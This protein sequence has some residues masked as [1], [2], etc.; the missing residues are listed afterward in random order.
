MMLVVYLTGFFMTG[1]L[2]FSTALRWASSFNN[3]SIEEYSWPILLFLAY[4]FFLFDIG[5]LKTFSQFK[6]RR[7]YDIIAVFLLLFLARLSIVNETS[8]WLDEHIQALYSTTLLPVAAGAIQHQPPG[9]MVLTNLGLWIS[10]FSVWGLRFHSCLFSAL[11]GAILFGLAKYLS[12]SRVFGLLCMLF[13]SVHQIVYKYGYEARPI[14]LGLFM[15][16]LFL[17][18]LLLQIKYISEKRNRRSGLYLSG[19]T[20]IYL[21]SL[22]LQPAF[23]VGL[24]IVFFTVLACFKREYIG[25]AGLLTLGL[26]LF[27]PLQVFI[28]SLAPPRFT[29][30]E[31]LNFVRTFE[32]FKYS[33]FSMLSIYYN[34]IGYVCILLSL[35]YAAIL[36]FRRKPCD[37]VT[38]FLIFLTIFFPIALIPYFKAHIEWELLNHYLVSF[39]PL[40]FLLFAALWGHLHVQIFKLSWLSDV[41]SI[42]V[43]AAM[44]K[45]FEYKDRSGSMSKEHQDLKSAYKAVQESMNKEDLLLS[46]CLNSKNFCVQWVIAKPFYFKGTPLD[47][48]KTVS[49][50]VYRKALMSGTIGKNIF[51]LYQNEWSAL[52][53]GEKNLI[54][55]FNKVMVYKVPTN[56]NPAKA[57]IDFLN[58]YV[59][60][61]LA[62]QKIYPEALAYLI[63][64]YEHLGDEK[65]RLELINIYR[66]GKSKDT[67]ENKYL[68]ELLD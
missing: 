13:F 4:V 27:I 53:P 59:Q 21:S 20:L 17:S 12:G 45:T 32:E 2:A 37:L 22:G 5:I 42:F 50:A 38:V 19:I 52:D 61:A 57:V 14:S 10:G 7:Y 29:L 24:S 36:H 34:P 33:N 23:I 48:A 64:S 31:G 25:T 63:V 8:V 54:G 47:S 62:E 67:P 49:V 56:S 44:A 11:A 16:L 40:V 41:L 66:Q 15:E 1:Y 18:A 9:D 26:A 58:P 3:V 51:F 43:F 46:F 30:T 39:L 6:I 60:S 65:S 35:I 55:R 28:F 68:D